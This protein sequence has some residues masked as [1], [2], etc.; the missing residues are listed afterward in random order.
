VALRIIAPVLASCALGLLA[1][2]CEKRD[3]SH[4]LTEA[5]SGGTGG[6]T[7]PVISI[8]GSS[9][10]G[11][12]GS[13]G[14]GSGGSG[15]GGTGA[16]QGGE[17]GEGTEACSTLAGLDEC[18]GTR[19]EAMLAPVNLLLVVD[20]SGSMSDQ[21]EGFSL[22]KWSAIKEALGTALSSAPE[23]V[24]FGLLAYPYALSSPIP[25]DCEGDLCCAVP[26]DGDA[27]N[28]AVGRDSA[29]AIGTALSGT[30]PGGGT[31]TAAALGR[32]LAYFTQGEGKDLEGDRYVLLATDGGPNCNAGLSCEASSCTPNL[33]GASQCAGV[34]CC[35]G[36][37]EFCLDDE[38]VVAAI[39][40]L[41]S[42]GISTFVVGIPGTEQ[43]TASL[44]AF[45]RAGGVPRIGADHDYYAVSA[46]SGVSGLTS[47]LKS[48][49]TELLRSCD[50]ALTKQPEQ[51]SL[52]NVAIDC[53][54]LP[55]EG[56]S[57]WEFDDPQAP[58]SLTISGPA[59][60]AIKAH[61]ARRVDV[62]YGCVT[63]H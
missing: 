51:P 53:E 62:V 25:L 56:E 23:T 35:E 16:S 1:G 18:G 40:E 41:R 49:T 55:K 43:Y 52:V 12:S 42:A 10:S 58:T 44:D 6:T 45:A 17:G 14:N 47:V 9:G 61:G 7:P 24:R 27:I 54:V 2:A 37:G 57:G 50:I 3:V 59:C 11:G 33:D 15:A 28:V 60:D 31:P 48:I 22:D 19:V 38:A 29:D 34:N 26:D 39:E 4:G 20:K 46:A 13:S 30:S 21:P 36:A 8:G 63:I 5:G 32:A